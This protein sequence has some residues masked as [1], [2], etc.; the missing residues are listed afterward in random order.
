M[1]K[2]N[3]LYLIPDVKQHDV[4]DI[5]LF[6][7]NAVVI[8]TQSTHAVEVADI[9]APISFAFGHVGLKNMA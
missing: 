8:F 2:D 1:L 7:I 9:L 4:I 6:Q 3:R 5:V